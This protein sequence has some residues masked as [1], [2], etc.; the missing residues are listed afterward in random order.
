[1]KRLIALPIAV[2]ILSSCSERTVSAAD[3]VKSHANDVAQVIST[4]TK[5]QDATS[6][7]LEG[8]RLDPA[9]AT[10]SSTLYQAQQTFA[11]VSHTLMEAPKP[12][13]DRIDLD[14]AGFGMWSATG[15]MV[16]AM[17]AGRAYLDDGKPSELVGYRNNWAT[18]R[19]WWNQAVAQIWL[20]AGAS[21]AEPTISGAPPA[22]PVN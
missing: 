9:A 15:K 1:M 6:G 20:A 8:A 12:K 11:A 16:D 7:G 4:V 22:P 3:Y 10:L 2:A 5:V 14:T 17:K 19:A 18:G 21:S 13:D